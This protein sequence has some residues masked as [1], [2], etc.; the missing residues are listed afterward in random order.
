MGSG[1]CNKGRGVAPLPLG[2]ALPRWCP[3]SV[4]APTSDPQAGPQKTDYDILRENFRWVGRRMAAAQPALSCL[5]APAPM[6]LPAT[7]GC[8]LPR[9][10]PCK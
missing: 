6:P 2:S 8:E 4:A 5:P 7:L 1:M 10:Q 3:F 9:Q